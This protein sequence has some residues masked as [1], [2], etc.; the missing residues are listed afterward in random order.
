MYQPT[1]YDPQYNQPDY[2]QLQAQQ[3]KA[4]Q[5]GA[6]GDPSSTTIAP[7][8]P[9]PP[10][11]QNH[12]SHT[13]T[14][15][16]AS[17][18]TNK[19]TSNQSDHHT[20]PS[21]SRND[22]PLLDSSSR[23]KSVEKEEENAAKTLDHSVDLDT[24]LKMLMK[25]KSSAVPAFLLESLIGEEEEEKAEEEV[26]T[27]VNN[28]DN[29]ASSPISF[30]EIKPLSRAPS[31]FLSRDHY[32]NCH[33]ENVRIE[34]EKYEKE[35]S[36]RSA[37]KRRG[38]RG[39][40]RPDSRNSDAMSLSSLSSGENNILE[41]GPV[42]DANS[43]QYPNYY[44]YPN[45]PG[46]HHPSDMTGYYPTPGASGMPG[47]YPMYPGQPYNQHH[48]GM[49][50]GYYGSNDPAQWGYNQWGGQQMPGYSNDDPMSIYQGGKAD[51]KAIRPLIR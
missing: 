15:P 1:A 37:Q 7:P 45:Y 32:L 6:N 17:S 23:D 2:W 46:G 11:L 38:R 14:P 4:K 3:W 50:H 28:E 48:P 29:N 42:L 47:S 49:P 40:G 34:R 39:G 12:H 26:E 9:I 19:L 8:L 24:R 18:S 31:P 41:E 30:E 44:G 20:P 13:S 33:S 21:M 36:Q 51:K 43:H 25:D 22:S 16:H 35:M 10:H 27:S 5:A